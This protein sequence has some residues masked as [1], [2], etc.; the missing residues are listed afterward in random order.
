MDNKDNRDLNFWQQSQEETEGIMEKLMNRLVAS[1]NLL[2]DE[3]LNTKIETFFDNQTFQK[4]VEATDKNDNIIQTQQSYSWDQDV[5][6]R[7]GG[8]APS[9]DELF[10]TEEDAQSNT[11]QLKNQKKQQENLF[12]KQNQNKNQDNLN[13]QFKK[14]ANQLQKG[15]SQNKQFLNSSAPQQQD[16]ENILNNGDKMPSIIKAEE[17][18]QSS[19]FLQ[20]SQSIILGQLEEMKQCVDEYENDDDPGFDLYE[21]GE[22]DF[23]KVAKQLAIQSGFPERAVNQQPQ[24]VA[25][26]Q[27]FNHQAFLQ[28]QQQQQ[29]N[30]SANMLKQ[31]RE[32]SKQQKFSFQKKYNYQITNK[33]DL[34]PGFSSKKTSSQ[35]EKK[36]TDDQ[37][38]KENEKEKK[39][40][41]LLP[42]GLRHPQSQDEFYPV[43]FDNIIYDCYDLKVIYDRE[44]TGFEETKE[45]PIV[46]NSTIA[47]RYQII[48]YLGSAAFSKAIQC[49]DLVTNQMYCMKIIENN[50]DYFD[51]SMDEIKLLKYI[52]INGDVDQKH[53]LRLHDYFYHKEHLFIITELLKDNLYEFY[54][55]NRENEDIPYFTMGRMQRITLQLLEGLEYIHSLHLMHC[56]LKPENILMK[57]YS[58]T[59]VKI[60]D[61]G[62]SCFI[63]DHL[64]SYIQSRS[65]RAPEV[66]I[67]C[68][69]D[70]KI[71]MWSL[72]C[73]LAELWTGQVLFQNDTVQG[74]LSK[75]LGIIGS[76]PEWMMNEGRLVNNFFTQEKLLYQEVYEDGESQ[77]YG[78]NSELGQRPKNRTGK[79]QILVPKKTNLRASYQ[80][81]YQIQIKNR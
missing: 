9:V 49:L 67:G 2:E 18:D 44:R 42:Q 23:L 65:Y 36:N 68:K 61:F 6:P 34:E 24:I 17:C 3:R 28:E 27:A 12:K 38:Q 48:E 14:Q 69:Y 19:D 56:D 52:N 79:I 4:M 13:N 15:N 20:N 10:I 43:N 40:N 66:I 22:Q 8:T 16:M 78:E 25:N 5:V 74:L 63:H 62:S 50:K 55:F 47:G 21:V 11:D 1:P 31:L 71:D 58:K 81:L 30:D 46:I 26:N 73:I 29:Q 41:I 80:K 51:Q 45:F 33:K 72:G 37:N 75:V 59:Q 53:V 64:S 76:F 7:F 35:N 39:T 32:N 77:N 60:I 57:S 70:Y 54:K